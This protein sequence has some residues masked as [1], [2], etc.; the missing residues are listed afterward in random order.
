MSQFLFRQRRSGA[1]GE[2]ENLEKQHG[3]FSPKFSFQCFDEATPETSGTLAPPP[4]HISFDNWPYLQLHPHLSCGSTLA[5]SCKASVSPLRSRARQRQ[6][7]RDGSLAC[8]AAF[9]QGDFPALPQLIDAPTLALDR[10]FSSLSQAEAY[11]YSR[12]RQSWDP[13]GTFTDR[14]PFTHDH[15]PILH[16]VAEPSHLLIGKATISTEIIDKLVCSLLLVRF[17]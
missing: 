16:L 15:K 17:Q 4:I 8:E 5:W 3:V 13:V 14:R 1:K 11:T 6:T 12:A 7:R 2:T 10:P 9:C